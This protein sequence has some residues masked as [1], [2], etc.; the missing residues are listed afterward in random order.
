MLREKQ[1]ECLVG[2]MKGRYFSPQHT[3]I[4]IIPIPMPER[5]PSLRRNDEPLHG[6]IPLSLLPLYPY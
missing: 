2:G 6:N 5:Q 1:E 3:S 4:L